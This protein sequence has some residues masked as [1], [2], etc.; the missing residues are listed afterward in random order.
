ML[1]VIDNY[2]KI[3]RSLDRSSTDLFGGLPVVIFIGDFFQFPPVWGLALWKEP[4]NGSGEDENGRILWHQFKEV[5]ILDE[6]M[7][8]SEDAPFHDLLSRARTG[9]LTEADRSFLNSKTITS[10]V[11][12]QLEDG[13]TVVKLNSLRYQVNRVRIEQFARTRY[14]NVYIFPALH[15]RTKS[16]GP[17][18]LRLHADDLLQQPDQGTKIPFPGLSLY[19]PNMPAVVLTNVC[20]LLGLVNGAAGMAVEVAID[21]TG[22][23]I[24]GRQL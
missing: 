6:Q 12:P 22:K 1:R 13:T 9:T 24:F 2:C 11:G 20:T 14:Q 19:T 23:L 8:Q 17:I 5:I 21:L 10:L 15:T 7:R 16:T 4:R 18:N 3:A